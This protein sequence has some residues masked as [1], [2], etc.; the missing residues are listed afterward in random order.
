MV[1][2]L[3]IETKSVTNWYYNSTPGQNWNI[4]N[5]YTT[6]R[7]YMTH[8]MHHVAIPAHVPVDGTPISLKV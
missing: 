6:I 8:V 5:N 1:V 4:I 7:R 2:T 3:E